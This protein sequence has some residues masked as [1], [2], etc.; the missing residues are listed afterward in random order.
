MS[1]AN[2]VP[3]STGEIAA[4]K[5]L[6]RVPIIHLFTYFPNANLIAARRSTLPNTLFG[7]CL[8]T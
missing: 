4:G 7:I 3:T 2:A 5:V 8:K 1:V 6:G